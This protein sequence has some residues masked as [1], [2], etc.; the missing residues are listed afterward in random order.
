MDHRQPNPK[1]E[2]H[3]R[4]KR[5]RYVVVEARR[6][7]RRDTIPHL[8]VEDL[9]AFGKELE[10]V[11][12]PRS[13]S[14]RVVLTRDGGGVMKILRVDWAEDLVDGQPAAQV[15]EEQRA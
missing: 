12:A 9:I 6:H 7:P 4:V 14:V 13:E 1:V 8:L 3:E 11:D 2:S 10:N 5:N 15:A